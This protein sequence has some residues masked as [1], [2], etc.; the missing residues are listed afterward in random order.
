ML[1]SPARIY[2]NPDSLASSQQA[3]DSTQSNE[4]LKSPLRQFCVCKKVLKD[5]FLLNSLK[6][7]FSK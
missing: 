7:Y 2:F 5:Y 4:D 3:R 6:P 1:R